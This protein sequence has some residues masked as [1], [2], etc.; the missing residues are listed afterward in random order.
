MI[1][2]ARLEELIQQAVE[3]QNY[4]IARIISKRNDDNNLW[5]DH[6]CKINETIVLEPE[7][8]NAE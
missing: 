3:Y 4:Q 5:Y 1:T 6:D 7:S 2:E 8:V